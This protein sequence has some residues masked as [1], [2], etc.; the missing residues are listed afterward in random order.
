MIQIHTNLHMESMEVC[1]YGDFRLFSRHFF[2]GT[3]YGLVWMEP[4]YWFSHTYTCATVR[5]RLEISCLEYCND[6]TIYSGSKLGDIVRLDLNDHVM[7]P[8]EHANAT[9]TKRRR[10]LEDQ[11]SS[12]SRIFSS[13]ST[14]TAINNDPPP[15]I[16]GTAA[17]V[18]KAQGSPSYRHVS[19]PLD[20]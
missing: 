2:L 16:V 9:T 4:M 10:R 3:H 7:R 20:G 18:K 17:I 14:I 8:H 6:G 11:K 5:L 12:A 13:Y 1:T 15:Q 19:V